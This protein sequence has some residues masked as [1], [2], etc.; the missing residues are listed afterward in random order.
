[1]FYSQEDAKSASEIV[2]VN[3]PLAPFKKLVYL[4][5]DFSLRQ[6]HQV[7]VRP[8]AFRPGPNV[9]KLFTSVNYECL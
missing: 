5:A 7:C 2:R 9:I 3:E 4:A 1:M 8:L 6:P